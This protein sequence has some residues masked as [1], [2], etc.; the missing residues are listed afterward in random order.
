MKLR[1]GDRAFKQQVKL[2][3]QRQ[4]ILCSRIRREPPKRDTRIIRESKGTPGNVN[5]FG[6]LV[7]IDPETLTLVVEDRLS[8]PSATD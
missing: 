5:I 2:L 7:N 1:R 8:K 4:R 6:Y 3:G